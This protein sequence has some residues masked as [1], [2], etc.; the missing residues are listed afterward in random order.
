[1]VVPPGR[2]S[3]FFSIKWESHIPI[4]EG[5]SE[6]G[7]RENGSSHVGGTETMFLRVMSSALLSPGLQDV[8]LSPKALPAWTATGLHCLPDVP[9]ASGSAQTIGPLFSRLQAL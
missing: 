6:E 7:M 3:V 8:G 9:D 2:A 1:M 5:Y 4:L